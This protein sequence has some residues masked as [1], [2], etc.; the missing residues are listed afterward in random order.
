MRSPNGGPALRTRAVA[1]LTALGLLLLSGAA[2]L[3]VPLTRW[4]WGALFI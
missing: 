1:A 4:V 3:L 2:P